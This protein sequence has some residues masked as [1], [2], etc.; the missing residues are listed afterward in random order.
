MRFTIYMVAGS[1]DLVYK[2]ENIQG[3]VRSKYDSQAPAQ[4]R[5]TEEMDK[6]KSLN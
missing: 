6:V 2:K 5:H 1:E 3:G 4:Q